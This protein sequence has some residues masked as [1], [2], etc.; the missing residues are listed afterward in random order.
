MWHE[1]WRIKRI[2]SVSISVMRHKHGALRATRGTPS[3]HAHAPRQHNRHDVAIIS[4][5]V[6]ALKQRMSAATSWR[7]AV[8]RYRAARSVNQSW[9]HLA[10]H[11]APAKSAAES[12][13]A[14]CIARA[15]ALVLSARKRLALRALHHALASRHQHNGGSASSNVVLNIISVVLTWRSSSIMSSAK[16]AVWRSNQ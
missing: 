7:N 14:R 1:N 3:P 5:I 10:H 12:D 15:G 16:T 13:A 11:G 6:M 9:R 8:A 4:K 2:S